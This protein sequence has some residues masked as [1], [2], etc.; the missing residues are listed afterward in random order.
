[1]LLLAITGTWYAHVRSR[2]KARREEEHEIATNSQGTF[3]GGYNLTKLKEQESEQQP[4]IPKLE[5]IRE[6]RVEEKIKA[7]GVRRSNTR[8]DGRRN[9]VML[10]VTNPDPA[11]SVIHSESHQ[12]TFEAGAHNRARFDAWKKSKGI[13]HHALEAATLYHHSEFSGSK[14]Q[15]T[16]PFAQPQQHETN[17]E[18]IAEGVKRM[19]STLDS[20]KTGDVEPLIPE[21]KITA[22][23]PVLENT[24]FEKGMGEGR[25]LRTF[26]LS[27]DKAVVKGPATFEDMG[28][29]QGRKGLSIYGAARSVVDK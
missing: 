5:K 29:K 13:Q 4:T 25:E 1:M 17:V 12:Q 20:W 11:L 22:A 7:A 27:G 23:T 19:R 16:I 8:E 24:G 15:P 3:I 28:L 14:T 6:A 9:G 18:I 21:V 10:Q 2:T 26:L